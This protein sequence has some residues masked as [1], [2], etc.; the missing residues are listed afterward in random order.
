MSIRRLFVLPLFD[1]C[2]KQKV[3]GSFNVEHVYVV[4][5]YYINVYNKKLRS[6]QKRF[7]SS[8]RNISRSFLHLAKEITIHVSATAAEGKV[9]TSVFEQN[10]SAG[11]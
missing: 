7:P 9:K 10:V 3:L 11:H 5:G 2:S 8:K 6:P 4:R 1:I